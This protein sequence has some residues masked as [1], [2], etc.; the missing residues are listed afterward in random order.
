MNCLDCSS[1]SCKKN[2]ADCFGL[3]DLSVAGYSSPDAVSTL[4]SASMLVDNG[5]AGT[6]SRIQELV[7]FCTYQKYK[8]IGIAYCFS[9]EEE[10]AL[11]RDILSRAGLTVIA[12]RC[13][14]GG[15]RENEIMDDKKSDAV[16]CN[17]AGQAAFLNK[18]ADFVIEMGLCLGHDVLL[19]KHLEV[20][21]TVLL[22]KD[23]VYNHNTLKGIRQSCSVIPE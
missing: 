1:K 16:S 2:G 7:E 5:R 12:S 14:T 15:I 11:V 3:H 4:K 17:P 13:T 19:H 6:L 18:R 10:A 8:V 21:F 20:P 22:V 9:I 23:R